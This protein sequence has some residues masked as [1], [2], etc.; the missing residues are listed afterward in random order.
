[1]SVAAPAGTSGLIMDVSTGTAGVSSGH[2]FEVDGTSV[3]F[4]VPI[5]DGTTGITVPDFVFDAN[6]ILQELMDV[7]LYTESNHHLP[8]TWSDSEFNDNH[9]KNG[10]SANFTYAIQTMQKL[11]EAY[12]YIFQENDE[13]VKLEKRVDALEHPKHWWKFWN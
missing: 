13:I 5:F 12:L 1:M 10:I 3:V 9:K 4:Y 6:F 8:G 2:L 11:E 7:R